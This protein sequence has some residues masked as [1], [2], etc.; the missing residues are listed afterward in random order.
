VKADIID[1]CNHLSG[2]TPGHSIAATHRSQGHVPLPWEKP[3]A[4]PDRLALVSV[5]Y[6]LMMNSESIAVVILNGAFEKVPMSS[7]LISAFGAPKFSDKIVRRILVSFGSGSRP[8]VR[9]IA[10]WLDLDR[11]YQKKSQ[12]GWG[13]HVRV[14]EPAA[15]AP[16]M[17]VA[18]EWKVPSITTAGDLARWLDLPPEHADWFAGEYDAVP[19]D[20][21]LSHYSLGLVK[22]ASGGVRLLEKPK[23]QMKQIQRHVLHGILDHIPAHDCSHGFQKKRSILTY[24]R[25]HVGREVLIKMDLR[26]YF[27]SVEKARVRALFHM[28]GYPPPVS[29]LLAGFTTN[30]IIKS[31]VPQGVK[32]RWRYTVSHLPQGA[33]SSPALAD[34]LLF[35][36]D[37]RLQSLAAKMNMQYTRYADDMAFSSDDQSL[38]GKRVDSFLGLVD[39]IVVDE[40]FRLNQDKTKVMYQSQRQRLAGLVVNNRTNVARAQYDQLRAILHRCEKNGLEQ[41]NREDHPA[42]LQ[43][44]QGRVEFIR[45]TNQA[46]GEKLQVMLSRLE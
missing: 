20:S 24:V 25:P 4:I 29:A 32:E 31:S 26:N 8:S 34:R 15:M 13:A 30:R 5:F 16:D 36:T 10:E 37:I 2:V 28:A 11:G 6:F 7:R 21:N 40:G 46:R 19:V 9:R 42:F 17:R 1:G 18:A 35:R 45:G 43:H 23:W 41:E 33:P 12:K 38:R 27:L 22:K 44:L 14:I 3:L 39:K